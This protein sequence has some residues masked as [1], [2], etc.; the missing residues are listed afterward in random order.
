MNAGHLIHCCITNHLKLSAKNTTR[1][2]FP[3]HPA[4]WAGPG[5]QGLVCLLTTGGCTVA[6]GTG[7]TFPLCSL[8][9]LSHEQLV[10]PGPCWRPL[11]GCQPAHLHTASPWGP[12]AS[13]QHGS[14]RLRAVTQEAGSGGCQ[15]YKAGPRNC[16]RVTTTWSC[17]SEQPRP[18]V[19]KDGIDRTTLVR[20]SIKE[21]KNMGP[22]L[23]PP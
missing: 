18:P 16:L 14:C 11:W 19:S 7:G 1:C 2:W 12:R 8:T 13:S 10:R 22:I 6:R 15:A 23:K 3:C 17:W 4:V 21:S 20:R 9:L 5:G